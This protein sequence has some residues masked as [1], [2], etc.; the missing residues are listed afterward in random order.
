MEN[1][2]FDLNQTHRTTLIIWFVL[3]LSQAALL[4]FT[5][6]I[7]PSLLERGLGTEP[8]LG[9]NAVIIIGAAFLAAV[10]LVISLVLNKRSVDQ[11]IAEQKPALVQTGLIMGCA[12]CETITLIGMILGIVFFYPYFY[13]WFIVGIIGIFLHFPRRAN[14]EAASYKLPK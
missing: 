4:G 1:K 10:N 3:L 8:I 13:F 9:E 12:F 11:A 2:K 14:L 5:Y 6:T 7:E